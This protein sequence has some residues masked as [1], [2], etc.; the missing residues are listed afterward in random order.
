MV[1]TNVIFNVRIYAR[2]ITYMIGHVKSP[3]NTEGVMETTKLALNIE[4]A[5]QKLGL[6]RTSM[7]A[8]VR[9][10]IIGHV[11]VGRPTDVWR[12]DGPLSEKQFWVFQL[13]I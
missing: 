13:S 10:G 2:M 4:E 5:R 8:A 3:L 11:R 1:F 6:S 7:Y 9:Q 12:R